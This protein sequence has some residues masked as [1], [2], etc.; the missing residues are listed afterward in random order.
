MYEQRYNSPFLVQEDDG[1]NS[2]LEHQRVIS[3]LTVGLGVLFYREKSITLEPLPETPL[4]EGPGHQVPDV[5]LFDN[6][7]QL[8]RI[9]IEVAQPRTTQRDL[10]KVIY[11]IEDDEYGILEGFVYNYHSRE[12]FRYRK[13]DGGAATTSSVSELMGIN[14]NEFL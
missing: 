13:G 6:N 7:V 4:G 3:K 1:T 14:L 11:L 9:I 5:L 10:K 12:W 8:T 2:P